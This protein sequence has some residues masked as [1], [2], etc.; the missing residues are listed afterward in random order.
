MQ[1]QGLN[2]L[3]GHKIFIS[4]KVPKIDWNS[5]ISKAGGVLTSDMEK[6]TIIIETEKS[7]KLGKIKKN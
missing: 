3:S 7:E 2:L 4:K 6:A 5:L 1:Y